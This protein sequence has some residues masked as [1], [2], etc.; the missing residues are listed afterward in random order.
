MG[1]K[2]CQ[3]E[4]GAQ[5]ETFVLGCTDVRSPETAY[6]IP[7][8]HT[9]KANRKTRGKERRCGHAGR[10]SRLA[11]REVVK[12]KYLC[13]ML[14]SPPAPKNPS[15]VS[16]S[17]VSFML[18]PVWGMKPKQPQKYVVPTHRAEGSRSLPWT[19]PLTSCLCKTV[20]RPVVSNS[21]RPRGL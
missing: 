14:D 21:L 6:P 12:E 15:V 4:N 5:R 11:G 7:H 3:E 16:W 8:S 2:A 13:I 1:T 9:S 17:P 19:A 10:D 20:S 18:S